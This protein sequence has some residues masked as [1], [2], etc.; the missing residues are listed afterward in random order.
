MLVVNKG[1]T[2]LILN[3]KSFG[4]SFTFLITHSDARMLYSRKI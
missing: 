4:I 3:W 1:V 2:I